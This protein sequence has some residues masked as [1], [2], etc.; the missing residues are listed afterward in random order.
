MIPT[1]RRALLNKQPL[2][3]LRK[4]SASYNEGNRKGGKCYEDHQEK[5]K[6][7]LGDPDAKE[8]RAVEL[9]NEKRSLNKRAFFVSVKMR[10]GMAHG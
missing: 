6:G 3:F 2:S 7:S 4:N 9:S 5:R 10:G 8:S 1:T